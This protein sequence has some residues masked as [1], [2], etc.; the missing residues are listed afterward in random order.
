MHKQMT[1]LIRPE[2]CIFQNMYT[3]IS[4]NSRSFQEFLCV[5]ESVISL[6]AIFMP[7]EIGE[8]LE[9]DYDIPI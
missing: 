1:V 3:R 7:K 2:I 6:V 9:K 4:C 8:G 5:R